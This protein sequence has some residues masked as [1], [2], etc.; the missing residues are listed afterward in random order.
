MRACSLLHRAV[1]PIALLPLASC[2]WSL[3]SDLFHQNWHSL[4]WSQLVMAC[5][6]ILPQDIC[7]KTCDNGRTTQGLGKREMES[8]DSIVE[9]ACGDRLQSLEGNHRGR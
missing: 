7:Q 8:I 2:M 4:K 9:T 1:K 5:F 6:A 3:Q